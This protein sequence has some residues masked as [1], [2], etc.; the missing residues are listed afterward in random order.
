MPPFPPLKEVIDSMNATPPSTIHSGLAQRGQILSA[1]TWTGHAMLLLCYPHESHEFAISTVTEADGCPVI[2]QSWWALCASVRR[3]DME[4][5]SRCK[6]DR[7]QVLCC[8]AA[9]KH[10]LNSQ[11]IF[12]LR[13]LTGVA[14]SQ[15]SLDL[16]AHRACWEKMERISEINRL[17]IAALC[18]YWS[19]SYLMHF[20]WEFGN[21]GYVSLWGSCGGLTTKTHQYIG[22][23]PPVVHSGTSLR[24]RWCGKG[25][26][27]IWIYRGVF[28]ICSWLVCW[29]SRE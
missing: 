20:C 14:G 27:N 13:P 21:C 3:S 18:L 25:Q 1:Q 24:F 9:K 26:H 16:N 5:V 4:R 19:H 17:L 22:L 29:L 2:Y 23:P 11:S 7:C 6:M 12:A 28:M 8:F 10:R 15:T